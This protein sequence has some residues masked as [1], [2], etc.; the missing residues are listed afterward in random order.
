[1]VIP[2]QSS[3]SNSPAPSGQPSQSNRSMV[4]PLWE[5]VTRDGEVGIRWNLHRGQERA[6][7]SRKRFILVSAGWQSG[8]SEIGPPFLWQEMIRCGP[9]DYLVA[10]PTY[11]LMTKKV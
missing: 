9:G 2:S 4:P 3:S 6:L 8:K 11:L 10:S 5:I 1:M 7:E